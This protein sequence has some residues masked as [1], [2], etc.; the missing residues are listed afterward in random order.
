MQH[1]CAHFRALHHRGN[2]AT[3]LGA[4]LFAVLQS[5][6]AEPPADAAMPAHTPAPSL[7]SS[8]ASTQDVAA[9]AAIPV[10]GLDEEE[11][12]KLE[13]QDQPASAPAPE[14]APAAPV[15][16]A[17]AE[18]RR[19]QVSWLAS[20]EAAA[21]SRLGEL[22]VGRHEQRFPGRE[23]PLMLGSERDWSRHLEGIRAGAAPQCERWTRYLL[24]QDLKIEDCETAL[25]NSGILWLFAEEET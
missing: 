25:L 13:S 22:I 14:P 7:V 3:R 10:P 5:G 24:M 12:Q 6:S 4:A 23:R 17:R 16:D 15:P 20:L 1:I 18:M 11:L 19:K 21:A 9:A 2:S 8:P